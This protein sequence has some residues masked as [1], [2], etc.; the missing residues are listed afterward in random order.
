MQA[1]LPPRGMTGDMLAFD[2]REG[3]AYRMRL[4]CNDPQPAPGKTSADADEVD[5]RY[6][7]LIPNQSIE[8]AVIF[9]S[10]DPAFAGEMRMTRTFERAKNG[11]LVTVRAENVPEGITAED[12]AA[13]LKSTLDNL[14]GFVEPAPRWGT[15]ATILWGIVI[16]AGYVAVEIVTFLVFFAVAWRDTSAERIELA[17]ENIE[18]NGT[19]LGV[20][21]TVGMLVCVP[22]IVAVTRLKRGSDLRSY[23]G[24]R[25]VRPRTILFWIAILC[26]FQ[27]LADRLAVAFD[28]P[29]IHQFMLDA[30]LSADPLWL[31]WLAVIVAAPLFEELLFRGF[32]FHGLER[33]RLGAAGAVVITSLAWTVIH[34]STRPSSSPSSFCWVC[35]WLSL[36]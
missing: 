26:A 25:G 21:A 34:S 31:L 5:V 2:F 6:V 24:L 18:T 14:A 29:V 10:D 3:G 36:V 15:L 35:C 20:T 30:Y 33:G 7:R 8:Q 23:L 22:A 9:A 28:R 1:W 19:I 32:L 16:L 4:T 17:F 27:L 13:G 11:T 12:H